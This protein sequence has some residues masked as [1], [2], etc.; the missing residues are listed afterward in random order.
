MDSSSNLSGFGSRFYRDKMGEE[1][2]SSFVVSCKD[3]DLWIGIDK[4][5]FEPSIVDFAQ[6][7]LINLRLVLEKYIHS[8]PEFATTYTPIKLPDNSPDIAVQMGKAAEIAEVG[9]M[10]AVAG[11]FSEFIGRAIQKR[12]PVKEIVVENGGDIYMSIGKDLNLSVYAGNSAL[13]GKIGIKIPYDSTPIGICTS[14]GN[15]GPSFSFGRADAV[16]VACKN[17]ALADAYATTFGNRVKTAD[18]ISKAIKI[19]S[20]CKEIISIVIICQN[21]MGITG[22]FELCPIC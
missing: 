1:R 16:M 8:F 10:A 6:R 14:A 4:T 7:E 18:D 21:Q 9:P 12:F 22:Q 2:F 5:S 19:A 13:S 11:A 15:V 20:Q 3:S 17:T